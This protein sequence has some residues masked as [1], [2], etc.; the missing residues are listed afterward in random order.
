MWYVCDAIGVHLPFERLILAKA[1]PSRMLQ[2]LLTAE[3][4]NME[5]IST[6]LLKMGADQGRL[7]LVQAGNEMQIAIGVAR[8]QFGSELG[9]QIASVSTELRQR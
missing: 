8:S 2:G 7:A 4:C 6:G 1:A 9:H 5:G 3:G